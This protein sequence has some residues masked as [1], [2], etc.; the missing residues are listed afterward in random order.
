MT[1]PLSG[2]NLK[3]FYLVNTFDGNVLK[4]NYYVT[5]EL[6]IISITDP[7]TKRLLDCGICHFIVY[8]FIILHYRL[9]LQIVK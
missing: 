4:K 9:T 1:S 5:N 8:F 2:P 6:K 3:N 7:S